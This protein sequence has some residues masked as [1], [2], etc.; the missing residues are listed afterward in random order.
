M[1]LF[2]TGEFDQSNLDYLRDWL[3]WAEGT[4]PVPGLYRTK[5][6]GFLRVFGFN[7]RDPKGMSEEAFEGLYEN[8]NAQL[9]RYDEGYAF[10]FEAARRRV[11][12][13]NQGEF[14][15]PAAKIFDLERLVPYVEGNV[16]ETKRYFSVLWVPSS[17][18]ERKAVGAVVTGDMDGQ[19][20][21]DLEMMRFVGETNALSSALRNT[22]GG[23]WPLG[24]IEGDS[25]LKS[26]ISTVRQNV[27]LGDRKCIDG[28]LVDSDF[29]GGRHAML[30]DD[31]IR[32][33][34]TDDYPDMTED[35]ILHDL[36][37]LGIE[38]RYV[39]R[40]LSM[41]SQEAKRRKTGVLNI[42]LT[43]NK[44][45]WAHMIA[46][47][48]GFESQTN[49]PDAE[50]DAEEARE[51]LYEPRKAG[52]RDGELTIAVVTWSRDEQEVETAVEDICKVFRDNEFVAKLETYHA[53]E[54]WLATIP[55]HAYA[56][57]RKDFMSTRNYAHLAPIEAVWA[58]ADTEEPLAWT[59]FGS[60]P[61]KLS[62]RSGGVYHTF[63]LGETG[64]GKSV[65]LNALSM[66]WQRM[67]NPRVIRFDK[68]YSA[69]IATLC[70]GGEHIN[71]GEGDM[72]FQPFADVDQ[73]RWRARSHEW[74]KEIVGD[75]GVQIDSQLEKAI[76]KALGLVAA[77]PR[78][79][80]TMTIFR[81]F[82]PPGPAKDVLKMFTKDGTFGGLLDSNRKPDLSAN[83]LNLEMQAMMEP[84]M[85]TALVPTLTHIFALIQEMLDG[86]PTLLILDECWR[87][88]LDK[89]F[90]PRIG[91]W[92]KELRKYNTGVIL[93][94][95]ALADFTA[96]PLAATIVQSCKTRIFTPDRRAN[97]AEQSKHWDSIAM[98]PEKRGIIASAVP[99]RDYIIDQDG[100]FGVFSFNLGEL[101]LA[102]IGSNEPADHAEADRILAL[103]NGKRDFLYHW[104]GYKQ[105]FDLLPL[106]PA[107]IEEEI[108]DAAQ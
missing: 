32:I 80:R 6:G 5:D 19:D 67:K 72:A 88:L 94:T 99:A 103:P 52:V 30:G 46:K 107:P 12:A 56:N 91:Q 3:P 8:L 24:I 65:C 49:D 59:T 76:D 53:T 1:S 35:A 60:D 87:F 82:L 54:A 66:E 38:Y 18:I 58:G 41:P 50:V 45:M 97:E 106:V 69:R 44:S 10:W 89:T 17:K 25:Y 48:T 104:L 108:Y 7:G 11:W 62:L 85:R 64:G 22:L 21:D 47:I 27:R 42:A 78:D 95:Q 29:I 70:C 9:R 57:V 73:P 26:C 100:N 102:L 101:G 28:K 79:K 92:L 40:W 74:I 75:L 93:A 13:P 14:A 83:V 90:A 71:V 77:L 86:R 105:Q 23:I 2:H 98:G 68:G 20:P 16:F 15:T 96:S 61:F 63:L 34:Y 84:E 43:S 4:D 31:H 39:I 37:G 36:N 55:G 33:I 81:T 51:A